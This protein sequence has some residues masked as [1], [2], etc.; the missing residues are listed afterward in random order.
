MR[1]LVIEDESK[2]ADYLHQGLTE[3]GYIVFR[4]EEKN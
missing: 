3:S 1:I 4:I 2:T